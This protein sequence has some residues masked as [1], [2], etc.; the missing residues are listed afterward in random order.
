MFWKPTFLLSLDMDGEQPHVDSIIRSMGTTPH[1]A[2]Q[3]LSL[4]ALTIHSHN[5]IAEMGPHV[6][7]LLGTAVPNLRHLSL[8]AYEFDMVYLRD[9]RTLRV[10]LYTM[11]LPECFALHNIVAALGRCPRLELLA[12]MLPGRPQTSDVALSTPISMPHLRTV[13]M[14][15]STSLC[16][17]V[18]R[19]LRDVHGS[20]RLL[21]NAM[22]FD[23]PVPPIGVAPVSQ[24][25]ASMGDLVMNKTPPIIHSMMIS[26]S[27]PRSQLE[28]PVPHGISV[29]S[30]FVFV[31]QTRPSHHSMTIRRPLRAHEDDEATR[32][33]LEATVSADAEDEVSK[34]ALQSWPLSNVTH[35]D[36]REAQPS[37]S[38]LYILFANLPS[39]TTVMVKHSAPLIQPLIITLRKYLREEGR[40]IVANI[41]FDSADLDGSEGLHGLFNDTPLPHPNALA[42]NS[43]IHVLRF[44]AESA[45]EGLPLDTVEV[46]NE[47]LNAHGG[48]VLRAEG[49]LDWSE[50]YQD[51]RE[52]FVYEGILHSR[53]QD[54]DGTKRD[55]FV[56][57]VS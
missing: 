16:T 48:R 36:L 56:V 35:L 18:F 42:R 7:A 27:T 3:S 25:A 51:L 30:R 13:I 43:L 45:Q 50:L 20:A 41:V 46:V 2:L 28:T 29:H 34:N 33:V 32:I 24:L 39:V 54:L 15:G 5:Q 9:L 10:S 17:D 26:Q 11:Q 8:N 44:C 12:M 31:G 40:R 37:E 1:P 14:H 52:G 38:Y 57:A 55:S 22:D 47:S 49:K 23:V 6:E 19:A 4:G 21:V 53:R